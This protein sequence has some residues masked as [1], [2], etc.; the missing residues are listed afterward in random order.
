MLSTLLHR[1]II[2][3]FQKFSWNT[4][5]LSLLLALVILSG[6]YW[7]SG[8]QDLF[9]QFTSSANPISEHSWMIEGCVILFVYSEQSPNQRI[10]QIVN[11]TVVSLPC[12]PL[13]GQLRNLFGLIPIHFKDPQDI[14]I[15]VWTLEIL[16]N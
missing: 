3:L 5:C 12:Q 2:S 14:E 1:I 6:K 9:Y 11:L 13:P 15:P 4:K 10:S 7:V 16:R 8:K